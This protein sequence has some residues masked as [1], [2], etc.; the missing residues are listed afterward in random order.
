VKKGK[1]EERRKEGIREGK[2]RERE[3]DEEGKKRRTREKREMESW[4]KGQTKLR[5]NSQMPC[6]TSSSEICFRYQSNSYLGLDSFL[7][8][9][10]CGHACEIVATCKTSAH[11]HLSRQTCREP[12]Q[13]LFIKTAV[14]WRA[15]AEN[16]SQTH[17]R[18][19]SG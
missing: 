19:C 10:N 13:L 4:G 12:N 9:I 6:S 14:T 11:A 18:L 16:I 1:G 15:W 8:K 3:K 2:R 7:V 5:W 17:W